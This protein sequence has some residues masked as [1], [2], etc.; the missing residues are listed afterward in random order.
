LKNEPEGGSEASRRRASF[1]GLVLRE[2]TARIAR[3]VRRST[4]INWSDA[5]LP[6]VGFISQ[7]AIKKQSGSLVQLRN[8]KMPAIHSS[9][10]AGLE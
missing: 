5:L 1:L 9:K 3:A 10:I 6:R 4:P 2:K 7:R 8:K